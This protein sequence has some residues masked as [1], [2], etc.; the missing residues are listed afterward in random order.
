MVTRDLIKHEIDRLR[1]DDLP[2][3]HRIIR[4]L[5]PASPTTSVIPQQQDTDE[6]WDE[7]LQ[8]TYGL[9]RDEPLER[10]PQGSFEIRE[11]LE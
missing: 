7:F 10:G 3:L 2:F 5:I 11:A 1:E 8:S 9:F 4:A 6:S